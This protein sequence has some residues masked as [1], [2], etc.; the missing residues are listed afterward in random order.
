MKD[1]QNP[2]F[3]FQTTDTILLVQA[4]NGKINIDFLI[5]YELA[6]RGLDKNGAWVGF[7]KAKEIHEV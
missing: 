3:M 6:S 2:R 7:Q 5:S 1:E 4:I